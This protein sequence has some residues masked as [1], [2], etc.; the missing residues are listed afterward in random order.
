MKSKDSLNEL[1]GLSVNEL[2]GRLVSL[3]EELMKLR[4]RKVS[5]QLKESHRFK[6]VRRNIAKVRTLLV[7]GAKA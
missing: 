3:K 4:V 1:K 6:E 5:G 2:K 7:N